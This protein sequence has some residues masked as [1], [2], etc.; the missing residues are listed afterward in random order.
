MVRRGFSQ[1]SVTTCRQ[2]LTL[3]PS[4]CAAPEENMLQDHPQSATTVR[5]RYFCGKCATIYG[6]MRS[7]SV[8]R[9]WATIHQNF[10][11]LKGL[12]ATTAGRGSSKGGLSSLAR[13]QIEKIL[14]IFGLECSI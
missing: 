4:V 7:T 10:R 6:E 1:N 14:C 13:E 9:S 3:L 11:D 5:I 12:S 8:F 2:Q